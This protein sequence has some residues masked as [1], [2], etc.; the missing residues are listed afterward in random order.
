[1]NQVKYGYAR[2]LS[3]FHKYFVP[4]T[5]ATVEWSE[6]QLSKAVVMAPGR[7]VDAADEMMAAWRKNDNS[8][9]SGIS[10]HLPIVITALSKDYVP[11][12][13][14]YSRQIAREIDFTIPIDPKNRVFKVRQIQGDRRAQLLFL[15]SEEASARSMAMQFCQ[16]IADHEFR[17][18]TVPYQFAGFVHEWPVVLE[19]PDVMPQSVDLGGQKNITAIV[20][21]VTM[22]EAIPVFVA[23]KAGQPNDGRGTDGN[24]LDPHGFPFVAGIKHASADAAQTSIAL[25]EVSPDGSGVCVYRP[26]DWGDVVFWDGS[27][28]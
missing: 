26:E 8:A 6:R 20:V 15:A 13:G 10:S 1:V 25:P 5:D 9:S 3:E 16:W 4:T 18:F 19:T 2:W 27:E 17:R 24:R 28:W 11:A 14:N 12:D 23:P 7:M 21:D 22:R